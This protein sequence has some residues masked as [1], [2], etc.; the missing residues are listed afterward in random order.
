MRCLAPVSACVA[1]ILTT[2]QALADRVLVLPVRGES[3]SP[4]AAVVQRDVLSG[5]AGAGHEV[6]GEAVTARALESVADGV[7]DTPEEY[8]AIGRAT[9]ADWVVVGSVE[10][11]VV[12]QRVE[13]SACLVVDGR[14]ET[15]AREVQKDK[16]APQTREMLDVLL[17]REGIGS[18]AMP[19][20]RTPLP[21]APPPPDPGAVT[22]VA[23]EPPPPPPPPEPAP[24]AG[25]RRV[26]MDYMS[27]R[28]SVWP[29]YSAGNRFFVAAAQGFSVAA[30]RP[31]GAAGN[32]GAIVAFARGGYAPGDLGL[33]V[34]AQLGGNL[35]G[36]PALFFD[37]GARW[38]ITPSALDGDDYAG[39]FHVGPEVTL[40]GFVLF[41]APD[42]VGPDGRTF[43]SQVATELAPELGAALV[44]ALQATPQI[45]IEGHLGNLRWIPAEAGTLV[46]VG[47]TLGG[48]VRF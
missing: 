33:E 7:A 26:Q 47:A 22:Q 44:M 18:G 3:G 12:T 4:E 13:I 35:A 39:S 8:V 31:D 46:L 24:E 1:L 42:V 36:P 11:A 10:P 45:Q 9:E 15:V 32:P 16:S 37:A 28:E 34:F 40:G 2:G 25:P 43:Q 38:M 27:S 30:V 5:L 23:V 17:R 20:E 29:P 21:V 48:G 14:V 41:G 6:V 19:W